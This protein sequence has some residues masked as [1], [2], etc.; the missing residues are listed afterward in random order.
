M[1][2]NRLSAVLRPSLETLEQE[3]RRKGHETVVV[4]ILPP[5]GDRGPRY[6]LQ[7][8][9][10]K[11]FIR[12]NSNSYLGL[13]RHP[14]LKKAEEE[15]IEHFGVGPGAVR[16]ISGTYAPHVELEGHLAAFHGREAAMIFSSAYATVLS[17]VVPLT[18]DQTVLISDELNHN[19]II[20]AVRLARPLEKLIYKHLDLDNLEQALQKAAALGARRV[21]VITDGVFSMR[22]SHAPLAE[23]A[24]LVEQY[25]ERFAENAILIVD[26]S[27]GVGAFGATGR[28]TEEHTAAQ[29]D[30]LIGTLGKAFGVNGGYVVGAADLIAYL[31]ET[32]PMYIYSNPITPGE[33]AAA[34]AALKLVQAPEGQ[35]RLQ[36]LSAM[37]ERFR[38]GLLS[39]GYESFPGAHPVVPLLLRDAARTNRLVGFLR[40]QGVLA[41]A[42]VYP[43]VPKGEASIRFQISAEHTQ[44]DVDEVLGILQAARAA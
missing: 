33:A 23:I 38:Q 14:A 40:E 11:P 17:V 13:S 12:M 16:F 35:Q 34:V 30:V 25:D 22:G 31:R 44:R 24:R 21:L 19:C 3:G 6:L 9:G 8:Y 10:D 4:G 26:D 37:T 39:L 7:G 28:G 18:T 43:V 41:T 27:H 15:A 42:I 32:S 29:A 20:N 2:L 36:H 5:Q 1:P